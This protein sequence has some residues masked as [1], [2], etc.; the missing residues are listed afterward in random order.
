VRWFTTL[1]PAAVLSM[2][3]IALL[4]PSTTDSSMTLEELSRS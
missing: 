2:S 1:E 3:T 4:A